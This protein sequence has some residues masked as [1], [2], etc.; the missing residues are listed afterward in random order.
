MFP[1]LPTRINHAQLAVKTLDWTAS[2]SDIFTPLASQPWSMLLD[3]ADAPHMDAHW[4]I[5]VAAPVATLKVYESH[6]ELTYA[7]N[8]LRLD[9]S[10]CPFSQLQSVQHALFSVQKN[11]SLPFAGGALGSFNY[12]LGRRI[13]RLPS[14]ALDDINLPLAC[15]GFY[16]WA[17]MRSYQS[18]SWQLVHYLGDDA[19]NETLAW[20]EQ[21]RDFAQAGAESNTSFSLLTEFTP[22]IT[23]D[24]YQQKFNQVQSY[25][26]SGD[27]YQINLTQRFSADYQGSEWQAYLKLRSAN[28][29][30][31]SAFV[32]LEEGA[33][34]SISPERF[35]KLD[36]RQVETK[37]IKGTLPR[38]PDPDADKTNAILL[39]ASP[40]DRAENL[41]IVDLLRNDIGRV[42]SPGS[43]RVPKL[44]EVESFP[45]VHHLVSTVTAQL[46]ENKDAFDLLR[47]AFP[48]GSITGAPKIR[49]MEIIE[50]L[51]PSRRSI[52][53]GSI[54][55]ISQH[56]NMD[57]SITIRTLAAVDG[58][59]YCWAGGG[60]VA[61]SIAD[62]EYQ[63][64]F[65]KISRILPILEQE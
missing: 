44:F 7:G 65:D 19:L 38:L 16:D 57:T 2:T 4:D 51:E 42:A 46:A 28:V 23:R 26:A 5:L 9:T 31:F 17:L 64:T 21:Q 45:A 59:L 53:C 55:Y 62:S 50:E 33:I 48:G 54:G 12:D 41:M 18:D 8:T 56:G 36:G 6:S 15:I 13:E 10:E 30:P 58:K 22:Q 49:A 40:K 63:E 27:C 47:A 29:A 35:I 43:V 14:T 61:D 37:P 1:P 60:V 25:L 39:K 32:R 52:Y 24:Q 20:L 34:L 11:T 3:S